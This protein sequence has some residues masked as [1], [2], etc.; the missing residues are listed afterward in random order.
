M[1]DTSPHS[2]MLQM[3]GWWGYCPI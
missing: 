3:T 1:L 2:K